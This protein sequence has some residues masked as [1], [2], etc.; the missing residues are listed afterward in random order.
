MNHAPTTAGEKQVP[1]GTDETLGGGALC[2]LIWKLCFNSR[3]T[4]YPYGG[5]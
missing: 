1:R 5:L 2:Q 4:A 3:S